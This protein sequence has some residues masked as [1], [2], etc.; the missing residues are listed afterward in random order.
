MKED[1]STEET[2]ET[3]P[4]PG[5]DEKIY[6]YEAELAELMRRAFSRKKVLRIGFGFGGPSR[7]WLK[8]NDGWEAEELQSIRAA[9][10]ARP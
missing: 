1:I 9:G 4:F 5:S 7:N 3:N 10:K 8:L 6:I 2:V